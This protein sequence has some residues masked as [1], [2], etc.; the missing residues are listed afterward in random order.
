VSRNKL[1]RAGEDLVKNLEALQRFTPTGTA[2]GERHILDQ[3]FV[4]QENFDR[5]VVPKPTSPIVL[6]GKKGSGKS[7]ILDA[8]SMTSLGLGIPVARIRPREM[9]LVGADDDGSVASLTR[10]AYEALISTVAVTMAA[11]L[12]GLVSAEEKDLLDE[13]IR[14]GVLRRDF[15]SKLAR[16]LPR[17]AK[18]VIGVDLSGDE[19]EEGA[20]LARIRD[21]VRRKLDRSVGIF[22]VLID[23]TDQVAD[24]GNSHQI[25]RIWGLILAAR[26]LAQISDR[27]RVV[28]AVREEVWRRL[29][30]SGAGQRDQA[31]HF[32][33]LTVRLTPSDKLMHEIVE[34]RLIASADFCGLSDYDDPWPLFFDGR[35]AK[36]P[37]SKE[38][39]NW[40]DL[41]VSRSR[42]RPRDAVQFLNSLAV[43]AEERGASRISQEDIDAVVPGFSKKRVEFLRNEA[44]E[45]CPEVEKV[46]DALA[47]VGY[48]QGSFKASF[49][50]IREALRRVP[51]S[52]V[53][54]FKR[55]LKPNN[56]DDF[57][58][59]LQF[60]FDYDI[61]NARMSDNREDA[62][63]R[64]IRPWDDLTLVS[65]G[66]WADL[67]QIVW[68]V[69]P[70][71][72]DYLITVQRNEAARQGLAY[73]PKGRGRQ[74]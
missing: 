55:R 59:L 30:R 25:N 15:V 26:D 34:Q 74:G 33:K 71:F 37:T 54:L 57:L 39:R 8:I 19:A 28:V 9:K 61:L 51:S 65:H 36:I 11:E 13:G 60:L 66:R 35:G 7:A 2:E 12:R 53:T 50:V 41:V 5:L 14:T 21:V 29:S 69:N 72:R 3:V 64:F 73:K 43:H 70:A 6:I 56:D 44:E 46:V 68:E 23:D 20:A 16:V 48:D 18:P 22:Y 17:L 58:A 24:S 62:G 1:L 27:L 47:G 49:E 31:D 63:Y 67:Q 4:E 42:S 10:V 32:E 38:F 52:G 40:A 45:E